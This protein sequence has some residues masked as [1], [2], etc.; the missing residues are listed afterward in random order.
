MLAIVSLIFTICEAGFIHPKI[1]KTSRRN[2]TLQERFDCRVFDID[3]NPH[4]ALDISQA[5][6]EVD[7]SA[8]N[9]K[10]LANLEDWYESDL[11]AMPKPVAALVAQ[12]TSTAYDHALRRFYLKVLWFL[13]MALI[14]FVFVFL[15]GQNDRFRDSIV[16]SIVPF[17]PLLTWFIT[18]IRSNDDLASDQDKTMQLMDDMWLQICR[19]VLKG[20]ALKEAVRDSQDALYMRRAEGTLI[21][22]GIYNLKRSAFEGRAARRA[23]TFRREY[24]TAFPVADSE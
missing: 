10:K 16:V 19:G 21:F 11:G 12:Y 2:A 23:D 24:A 5:S 9:K 3:E 1:V 20:E 7:A 15:V 6:I 14:I 13:F 18:T 22:P 17:V 4:L 8:L